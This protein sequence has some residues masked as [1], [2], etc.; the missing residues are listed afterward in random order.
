MRYIINADDFGRTVTVNKAVVEGFENG[1][2]D[3]TTIMVNMPYF[4]EA[5]QLSEQYGFKD[6]VG[7]HLNI[8]SGIPLTENIKKCA[9][10]CTNGKFN[11]SIFKNKKLQI[12]ISK[13]ARFAVKEEIEAQIKKYLSAG[14]T[15]KHADSHGHIHTFPSLVRLIVSLLRQ[16][17]F[18]YL[19]LSLNVGI[20]RFKVLYK[21]FINSIIK[22]LDRHNLENICYFGSFR[23]VKQISSTLKFQKGTTEIMLHPNIFDGDV[24][25]GQGM[26]YSDIIEWKKGC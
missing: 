2:L 7:L 16:H 24:E 20:K 22:N 14:F 8:T 21:Y 9:D 25:V 23:D 4:E 26:H 3:Q 10:F 13:K 5:V 19:R 18:Y 17:N 1:C 15:L 11:G 12:F 6:K